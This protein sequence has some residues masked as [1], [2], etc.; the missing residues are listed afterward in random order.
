MVDKQLLIYINSDYFTT[1]NFTKW[2]NH[3]NYE[4]VDIMKCNKHLDKHLDKHIDFVYI[5]ATTKKFIK[6]YIYKNVKINCMSYVIPKIE[7]YDKE[8]LLRHFS[9]TFLQSIVTHTPTTAAFDKKIFG[10]SIVMRIISI[11]PI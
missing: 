6:D 8:T 4:V 11:F 2:L 9:E 10:P 5:D 1:E 3:L 7:F